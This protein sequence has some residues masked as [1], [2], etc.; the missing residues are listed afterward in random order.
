MYCKCVPVTFTLVG[1][2]VNWVSINGETG[3]E[4]P[5]AD[6]DAYA[7]AIDRLLADDRL[8]E[9]YAE[10]G[11]KRVAQLFTCDKSVEEA[12][13]AFNTLLGLPDTSTPSDKS[14]KSTPSE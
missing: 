7:A 11:R 14:A 4:V 5:L 1:S 3:E 6:V 8:R 13:K 12:R 2:G 10:A 9:R